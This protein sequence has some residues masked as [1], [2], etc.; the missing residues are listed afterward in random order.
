MMVIVAA[1]CS[2][3]KQDINTGTVLLA[4]LSPRGPFPRPPPPRASPVPESDPV[5]HTEFS[6]LLIS[7]LPVAVLILSWSFVT[8]T[9]LVSVRI[10]YFVECLSVLVSMIFSLDEYT[11]TCVFGKN[12]SQMISPSHCI[13]S[14][15]H[16]VHISCYW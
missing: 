10:S 3:Q 6:C 11:E 13:V 15:V 16:G 9:F 1:Q 12:T 8:L 2:F 7:F 4:K 5:P 14:G